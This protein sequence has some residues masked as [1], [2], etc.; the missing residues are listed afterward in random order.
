MSF[1]DIGEIIGRTVAGYRQKEGAKMDR[2]DIHSESI[3]PLDL[4]YSP[5]VKWPG[6]C[7]K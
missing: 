1:A 7:L 4:C 2:S 6:D 3:C 5:I